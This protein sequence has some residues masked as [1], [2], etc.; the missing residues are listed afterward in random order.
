MKFK[1]AA[2][3]IVEFNDSVELDINVVA[4]SAE[5]DDG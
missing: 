1:L 5:A 4:V 3:A 2:A